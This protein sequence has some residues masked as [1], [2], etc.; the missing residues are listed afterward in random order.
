M[1]QQQ[2]DGDV[3]DRNASGRFAVQLAVMGVAVQGERSLVAVDYFSETRAA[4]KRPDFLRLSLNCFRY[5]GVMGDD[6]DFGRAQ[7]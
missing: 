2:G 7:H 1:S 6:Y 5:R 4:Q 3:M